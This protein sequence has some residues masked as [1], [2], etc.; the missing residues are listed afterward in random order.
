MYC[1][2]KGDREPE[3]SLGNCFFLCYST[4]EVTLALYVNFQK[5]PFD[6]QEYS[7]CNFSLKHQYNAQQTG[8]ENKRKADLTD[9]RP[10]YQH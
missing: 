9:L 1:K 7:I 2:K 3:C 5:Q 6:S 8:D 4:Y 10:N